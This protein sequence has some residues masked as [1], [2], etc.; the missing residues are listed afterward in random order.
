M[1]IHSVSNPIQPHIIQTDLFQLDTDEI[2]QQIIALSNS[3]N[4]PD[5]LKAKDIAHKQ[6]TMLSRSSTP[7]FATPVGAAAKEDAVQRK[8]RLL[9]KFRLT[10]HRAITLYNNPSIVSLTAM[11]RKKNHIFD[12]GENKGKEGDGKVVDMEV[13]SALE[14]TPKTPMVIRQSTVC[15]CVCVYMHAYKLSNIQTNK[16]NKI[17]T[18]IHAYIH[19][20]FMY[21]SILRLV[22]LVGP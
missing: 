16:Q 2:L 7:T 17:R 19:A 5:V 6:K 20:S 8:H 10:V 13:L 1:T 21:S 14:W 3:Q 11:H 22:M 4:K 12:N 9:K 15:V 18:H